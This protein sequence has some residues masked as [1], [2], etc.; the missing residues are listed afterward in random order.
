MTHFPII[1]MHQ[2]QISKQSIPGNTYFQFWR[3]NIRQRAILSIFLPSLQG[4]ECLFKALTVCSSNIAFFMWEPIYTRTPDQFWQH[5]LLYKSF[6]MTG[7][8]KQSWSSREQNTGTIW[9]IFLPKNNV[10]YPSI[11][12][13][14]VICVSFSYFLKPWERLLQKLFEQTKGRTL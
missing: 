7:L 8:F 6:T 14:N 10:F 12:T 4:I 13:H 2:R 3:Y 5:D 11:N 9:R 1:V